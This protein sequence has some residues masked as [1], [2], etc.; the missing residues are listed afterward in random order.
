MKKTWV[1]IPWSNPLN[2]HPLLPINFWM[3]NSSATLI[4]MRSLKF[5]SSMERSWCSS[6]MSINSINNLMSPTVLSI[7]GNDL[8]IFESLPCDLKLGRQVHCFVRKV[9]LAE[10]SILEN[11]HE[12]F[13]F[14]PIVL[15]PENLRFWNLWFDGDK[16]RHV[17]GD[18]SG[19]RSCTSFRVDYRPLLRNENQSS[20][21]EGVPSAYS[22]KWRI[23]R[24]GE[25]QTNL[26]YLLLHWTSTLN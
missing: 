26:G 21:W 16:T 24:E 14:Q 25:L 11:I 4:S 10:P 3:C 13:K 20:L 22:T 17:I 2:W 7:F 6:I 12:A 19:Q 5:H 9:R 23:D 1:D 18:I 8:P 15:K